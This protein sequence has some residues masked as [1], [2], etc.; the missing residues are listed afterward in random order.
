MSITP[1]AVSTAI[2]TL[3]SAVSNAGTLQGADA[4][5]RAPVITAAVALTNT[6]ASYIT[7]TDTTIGT[8]ASNLAAGANPSGAAAYLTAQIEAVNTQAN[9][10]A[11]Q[12]YASR[13]AENL[14]VI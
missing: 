6:I 12:G 4:A 13:I 3:Q 5:T 11:M 2:A 8:A 14:A 9:L 7:V 1:A 10:L